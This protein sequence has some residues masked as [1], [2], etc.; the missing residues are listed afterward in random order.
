LTQAS[1]VN[2]N[3]VKVKQGVLK[4]H[5]ILDFINEL[6]KRVL[7]GLYS[8]NTTVQHLKCLNCFFHCNEVVIIMMMI[9]RLK[10]EYIR[11]LRLI[12]STELS[13]RNKM[14]AI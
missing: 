7:M 1:I 9:I 8:V 12:L 2:D 3:G 4:G 10:K 13:A 6:K 5:P 14:Q 11:R